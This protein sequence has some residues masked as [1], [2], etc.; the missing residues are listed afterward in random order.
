MKILLRCGGGTYT[1][2]PQRIGLQFKG[3]LENVTALRPGEE[4]RWYL[5]VGVLIF[6]TFG[7]GR[8]ANYITAVVAVC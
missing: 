7:P 8:A 1:A 5:K 4:F 3:T 2:H 6:C